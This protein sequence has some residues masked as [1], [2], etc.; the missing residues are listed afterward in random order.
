MEKKN[1]Y[2][3]KT[4]KSNQPG[5][6]YCGCC[7]YVFTGNDDK[8]FIPSYEMDFIDIIDSRHEEILSIL[9]SFQHN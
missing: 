4:Y 5:N 8:Y 2:D 9:C 7:M 1:S 6:G 3:Y